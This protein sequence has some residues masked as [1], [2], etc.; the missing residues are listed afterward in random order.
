MIPFGSQEQ[1][2]K[3]KILINIG[4]LL[5]IP[6]GFISTGKKG[7]SIINGG[8]GQLTGL[9]GRGN[10][11]KST[12]MHYMMLSAADK[13]MGTHKTNMITYDTEINIHPD[14]LM[15]LSSKFNNIPQDAITGEEGIWSIMDK[16]QVPGNKFAV[17]LNKFSE[18]K[19]KDKASRIKVDCFKDP[20]SNN[21]LEML[22]PSFMEIDSL[23]EF[24][25]EST[26]D[27][28]S[29]DLDSSDTNTF[30]MKQGLFKSKFLSALPR[31]ANMSNTYIMF[32]AHIG[33]KINM[34]TGPAAMAAPVK[35]LQ[36]LK[37]G[38]SIKGIST[39][40]FFLLNNAWFLHTAQP[41]VNQGTK[42]AEYPSSESTNAANDLNIVRM[43]QLRSKS[44]SSGYTI[45]IVISQDEGVLPTLTEFHHIKENDRFGLS[46]NN[47]HY[48]LDL[49]PD[50]SLQRTTVRTKIDSDPKLRRAINITSEL[51]QL[52]NFK[53][54]FSSDELW[55]S[56]KELYEDIK[57]LGY[58]W[59][60][61]LETR[62]YWTVDQYTNPI[63]FLSTIDLLKM[64]KG[65][66]TPYFLNN[67]KKEN[68]NE[69]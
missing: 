44:G 58:D 30:A 50:V 67:N 4:S 41:L 25:A 39:K 35:D 43:T 56:P 69:K 27:M 33:S 7:E 6:T 19:Q 36:Y 21:P 42:L 40:F 64:R 60:V 31:I 45:S 18:A 10:N 49:Y 32:T 53:S 52:K 23:S 1:K 62:G 26:V 24:E 22:V 61:L 14:R 68:K 2:I 63:P 48:S 46:G 54:E 16:T 57:K 15:A 66:Y 12:I 29:N 8:L 47:I 59:N 3:P 20:Y 55:C 13:V 38:D 17:E 37:Q 34:A 65:L 51:L 9:V 28:L 11:Y 5:D